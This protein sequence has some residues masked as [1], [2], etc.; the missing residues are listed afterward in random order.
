MSRLRQGCLTRRPTQVQAKQTAE[1]TSHPSQSGSAFR[2]INRVPAT[3]K[4]ARAIT[5]NYRIAR[6]RHLCCR[7]ATFAAV[8]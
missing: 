3:S 2:P 7:Y 1:P 8:Y 6:S 4:A 5:L